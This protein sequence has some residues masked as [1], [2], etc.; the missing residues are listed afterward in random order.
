MSKSAVVE[1][2]QLTSTEIDQTL[3]KIA[4]GFS[5]QLRSPVLHQPSEVGLAFQDVTF[6][7]LDGTPLEGWF[8]PCEGSRKVIV[9]NHP[10]GFSRSGMPTHLEPWKSAWASSGND[11]EVNLIPDY[12]ILHDAGYNVLTYDLR[13]FRLSSAANG[14]VGSSGIFESRDVIGSLHYIRSR[15]DTRNML[16]GL[17]SRCL[18]CNSTLYAMKASPETF[19]G[20]RCLV[21]L[22][23]VDTQTIVTHQLRLA[24]LPTAS[25]DDLDRRIQLKTGINF[26]ARNPHEWA[27]HVCVPTFLYQVHDDVLTEP[28]DVQTVFDNMPLSEKELF[29]IYG[30]DR[31]WDGYAYFQLHPERMLA[32]FATHMS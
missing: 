20:V 13:N 31:R 29:W 5:Q 17:F 14:G 2:P 3:Q 18:G 27:K 12:K 19:A 30:T 25:I 8:I 1:P 9:C 24:G 22:Q 16:V 26:A 21:K 4:D 32:W 7:S 6:P 23:P 10:M 15:P 11:F 28:S